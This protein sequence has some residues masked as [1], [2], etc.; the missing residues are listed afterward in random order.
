MEKGREGKAMGP[1]PAEVLGEVRRHLTYLLLLLIFLASFLQQFLVE[2]DARNPFK[3]ACFLQD[4]AFHKDPECLFVWTAG[5]KLSKKRPFW[6]M[7]VGVGAGN[8]TCVL[9]SRVLP[10]GLHHLYSQ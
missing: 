5:F 9:F 6:S 2:M 1:K 8:P 3:I 7:G 10:F 4:V